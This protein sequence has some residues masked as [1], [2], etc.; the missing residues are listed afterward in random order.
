M[1]AVNRDCVRLD[2]NESP[3]PPPSQV[4]E[5]AARELEAVNRYPDP[6]RVKLLESM[7]AEYSRVPEGYVAVVNG[8]DE[9]LR[10]VMERLGGNGVAFPK[11]SFTMYRILANTLK[12]PTYELGMEPNGDS[13]VLTRPLKPRGNLIIID[14]P[15][16]P[17]GSPLIEEDDAVYLLE[18]GY[19][20]VVDEAYYEF[21]GETFAGL[22]ESYDN[23]IVVR[24]L[25]K[26]F[27]LAGLRIGYI[28][29]SPRTL[30]ALAARALPFPL[31]RP[32]LEA[33]ISA[34]ENRSYATRIVKLIN[35]MKPLY[36]EVLVKAG[37]RV[38]ESRAN[39]LL[40]RAPNE[41]LIAL[42]DENC[43]RIK[44]TTIGPLWVRITVAGSR[45][46]NALAAALAHGEHV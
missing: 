37:F 2:L 14:S 18:R 33:A 22:A 25:S 16:N 15:N 36:K 7:L 13:W 28:I 10:I 31:S 4:I 23:L 24:T 17:T 21:H 8:G 27:A 3:I 11:Y 40:A 41:R 38:Y 19:T 43:V 39:F 42:L 5:A 32:S 44:R 29:A 46:L 9:A 20:L 26:A 34:L 1:E 30:E 6:G 35:E 45:E 12:L